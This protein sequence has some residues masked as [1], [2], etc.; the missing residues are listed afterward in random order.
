MTNKEQNERLFALAILCLPVEIVASFDPLTHK[1]IA[2]LV[3]IVRH[4]L[5]L[6]NEGEETDLTRD[7]LADCRKFLKRFKG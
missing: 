4:E 1:T 3:Y 6:Y 2:D 5:D 7:S